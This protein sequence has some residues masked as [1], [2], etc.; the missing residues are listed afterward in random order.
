MFLLTLVFLSN[1]LVAACMMLMYSFTLFCSNANWIKVH[2][3]SRIKT[4][5]VICG[6]V[7]LGLQSDSVSMIET[8]LLFFSVLCSIKREFCLG[9]SLKICACCFRLWEDQLQCFSVVCIFLCACLCFVVSFLHI[10]G[11]SC[12][13]CVSCGPTKITRFSLTVA[14]GF[15][16]HIQILFLHNCACVFDLTVTS[17]FLPWIKVIDYFA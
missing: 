1:Y 10:D 4:R 2:F 17:A 9:A 13:L 16:L 5:S 12:L 6:L 7:T 3:L 15:Q 14:F 8:Y 11:T